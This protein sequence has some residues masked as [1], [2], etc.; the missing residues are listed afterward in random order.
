MAKKAGRVRSKRVGGQSRVRAQFPT[1]ARLFSGHTVEAALMNAAVPPPSLV[2][3]PSLRKSADALTPQEQQL[4]K[5][6]IT[7]SIA[8]GIYSRLVRIHADM[9][10][11]MHTMPGMP[12]GTLRFL[13]WHRLYLI[14]F[15]QAMRAFDAGFVVPYWRWMDANSIPSWMTS[16]KPAGVTDA[17]GN[18]IPVTRAPGTDPQTPNLP[19]S[20]T[21]QTTV[22]N[23]QDYHSFTLALEGAKPYGAHNLVHM[24]LHG[25]MSNVPAAPADPMFWMHHAEIDRIWA[26]WAKA[27]PG[28]IPSLSGASAIL[29]PWPETVPEMLDTTGVPEYPYTYDRM[30]L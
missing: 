19:T 11:D 2:P 21:I 24:W 8:D 1:G 23:K 17:N 27:N 22:M 9:T 16:F 13:P 7:K 14:K 25:T 15:E 29:D 26:I 20:Q 3:T 18:P 28:Q 6:V 12:A 30:I 5:D 4:F 10:H